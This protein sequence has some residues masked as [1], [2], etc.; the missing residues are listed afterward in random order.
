MILATIRKQN[1]HVM[2][3]RLRSNELILG[4][5]KRNEPHCQSGWYDQRVVKSKPTSNNEFLKLV[6]VCDGTGSWRSCTCFNVHVFQTLED[7]TY[8][9]MTPNLTTKWPFS[10]KY[11]RNIMVDLEEQNNYVTFNIKYIKLT[12]FSASPIRA[13]N[14]YSKLQQN[15]SWHNCVS[16]SKL[17][18][19]SGTML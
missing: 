15:S 10:S 6:S 9:H 11:T 14:L 19:K 5:W 16:V 13:V 1:L 4:R 7:R 17:F 8:G 2:G 12:L 3:H 18:A